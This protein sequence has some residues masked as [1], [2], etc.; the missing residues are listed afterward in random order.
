MDTKAGGLER[1]VKTS[2]EALKNDENVPDASKSNKPS[3]IED[4]PDPDEDDLD[5]LD[6]EYTPNELGS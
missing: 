3:I 6:G 1:P 2:S 5:D 4:A